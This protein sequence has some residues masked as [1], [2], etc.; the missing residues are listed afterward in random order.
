MNGSPSPE[1]PRWY[2]LRVWFGHDG[3]RRVWR[4]SV[5]CADQHVHFA[6]PDALLLYLTHVLAV[7][8]AS[9]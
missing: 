8:A 4:A 5:R 3:T 7:D 1:G 2:V 6:S 9:T